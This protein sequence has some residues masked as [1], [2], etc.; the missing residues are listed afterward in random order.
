MDSE[1]DVG[2]NLASRH[3]FKGSGPM[4]TALVP[5]PV[6]VRELGQLQQGLAMARFGSKRAE[7]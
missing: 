1:A 5:H 4:L 2:L 6:E 3:M 7:I